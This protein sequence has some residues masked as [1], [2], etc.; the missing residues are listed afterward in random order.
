LAVAALVVSALALVISFWKAWLDWLRGRR[1]LRVSAK[2]D[3]RLEDP[4][5][6]VD[7][8]NNGGHDEVLLRV[9]LR[10]GWSPIRR[11]RTG[12][13]WEHDVAYLLESPR[14]VSRDGH[15]IIQVP[16]G[17]WYQ[18]WPDDRI[19]PRAQVYIA[20]AAGQT[21]TARVSRRILFTSM[22]AALDEAERRLRKEGRR[23]NKN[24]GQ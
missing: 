12:R 2:R 22:R 14:E 17:L 3:Y 23:T 15:A 10:D 16:G 7:V 5:L 21:H 6:L 19:G 4:P 11:L 18:E 8:V 24:A 20:T 1:S 13:W 9:G